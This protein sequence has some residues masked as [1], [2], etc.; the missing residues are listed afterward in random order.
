M[1]V[2]KYLIGVGTGRTHR[3][4]EGGQP[5]DAA[6]GAPLGRGVTRRSN[7]KTRLMCVD[8]AAIERGEATYDSVCRMRERAMEENCLAQARRDHDDVWAAACWQWLADHPPIL[9]TSG[10]DRG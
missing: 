4:R 1:I 7:A 6:C 3:Q 8:C 2:H 10:G 5:G 9:V